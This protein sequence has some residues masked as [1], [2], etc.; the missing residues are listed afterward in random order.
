MS[1]QQAM[2]PT[3][4]AAE[5]AYGFLTFEIDSPAFFAKLAENGVSPATEGEAKQLWDLGHQV[6]Q[7]YLAGHLKVA[8]APIHPDAP[9]DNPFLS[10]AIDSVVGMQPA[11]VKEAQAD[12][13]LGNQAHQL[14]Q[15]NELAKQAALLCAYVENGGDLADTPGAE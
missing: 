14:V 10:S 11:V 7:Q 6:E 2:L 15:G 3:K 13:F 5:E 8:N 4:A 12:E 9:G 1:T